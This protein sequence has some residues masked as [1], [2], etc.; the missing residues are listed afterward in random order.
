MKEKKPVEILRNIFLGKRYA[1]LSSIDDQ[2]RYLTTSSILVAGA[3]PLVFFGYFMLVFDIVRAA[4]NFGIAAI[5]LI[6]FLL[7]RTKINMHRV[8]MIPVTLFGAYCAYLV[9]VGDYGLW[10]A[11]WL[12]A[13]PPIAIFLSR[14]VVGTIISVVVFVVSVYFM[15]SPM[16]PVDVENFIRLRVI[17]A[18]ILIFGLTLI[19]EIIRILKERREAA[20]NAEMLLNNS[21]IQ[22]MKDN[23]QQ[24]IFM[25]DSELK[26]L[27]LYSKPLI[28]ILS[29]YESELAGKSFLDILATSLDG[30]QLQ[31][32]K[33][34]FSMIFAKSKS[35]KVLESANPIAELE[36]KIDNRIKILSTK[37]HLIEKPGDE[38]LVIGLIQD[39]TKEKEA[40]REL[41]A[42]REAQHLEMKNM[43]DII[44]IDPIIFDDFI[45]STDAN[46]NNINL[47]LKDRNLSEKQAV[48]KFF[49]IV[50]AMKSNALILGLESFGRKLHTLEDEIKVLLGSEH[51]IVMDDI[52][53]MAIKLETIMQDKDEYVK[54]VSRIQSYR[55]T[56][57]VDSILVK[58]LKMAVDNVAEETNKKVE[59]KAEKLDT[60]VLSS[61]LRKPIKDILLQCIRNSVYHGIE[62]PEERLKKGKRSHGILNISIKKVDGKA[63]ITFS[64]DGGGLNWEKIKDKYIKM[65]PDAKD[66]SKKTLLSSI[67]APEFSTSEETTSIAGRGV[68]LSLVKDL[69]KEYNGS[70]NV[71]SS[72][73]GLTFKFTFPL[74]S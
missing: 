16:A 3:I 68:G 26:I 29:Y 39:I 72:E 54:I 48:T 38:N 9:F 37:F 4:I 31:T 21:I 62:M 27:P 28:S 53:N 10:A 35:L 7:L 67:F 41:E 33:G 52:L 49:Q 58:T 60:D 74:A 50:H 32:M 63:E 8:V 70:I 23:I 51:N 1:T 20:L 14:L 30:R 47:I 43:F 19:Y 17:F 11:V 45:E 57:N 18:F 13:L 59:L 12:F 25:M 56:H 22:T 55:S 73:T 65:N 61:G 46:F 15:Y 2:F 6:T 64:D 44:Q 42:Q 36:Y 66:L 34:Y 69:V 71:N 40:E 24:G 5:C